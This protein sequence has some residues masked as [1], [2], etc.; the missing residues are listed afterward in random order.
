MTSPITKTR[1]AKPPAFTLIEV[2]LALLILSLLIGAVAVGVS[3][4]LESRYLEEGAERL[5]T[6]LRMA[7]AEA[8]NRGR[9]LRLDVS[10]D[11]SCAMSWEP[12]PLEEPGVFVRYTGSGWASGLPNDLVRVVDCRVAGEEAY[13]PPD[14]AV[15]M[16]NERRGRQAVIEPVHFHPDGSCESASIELRSTDPHDLRR[17]IIDVDGLHGLFTRRILLPSELE[18]RD[19]GN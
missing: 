13:R 1:S 2:L 11:G 4:A 10:E 17:A 12:G 9:R 14:V 6:A 19:A 5:E 7:R 15:A 18:E 16:S 3:G 8:A